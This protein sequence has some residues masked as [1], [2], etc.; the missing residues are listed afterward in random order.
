[1][2]RLVSVICIAALILAGCIDDGHVGPTRV[3][4]KIVVNA[5]TVQWQ[6]EDQE[7]V[8]CEEPIW[9]MY[10][11]A[12][13]PITQAGLRMDRTYEYYCYLLDGYYYTTNRTS[14]EGGEVTGPGG[15]L[16]LTGKREWMPRSYCA[17]TATTTYRR[18]NGDAGCQ[19]GV[20]FGSIGMT[21]AEHRP[22]YAMWDADCA[23][24]ENK[25]TAFVPPSD[26][27]T[28]CNLT[29]GE[30]AAIDDTN[31]TL[32]P[33]GIS[34]TCR[35]VQQCGQNGNGFV[36]EQAGS[37]MAGNNTDEESIFR[38]GFPLMYS[39]TIMTAD[40]IP[41]FVG[42]TFSA[43]IKSDA[44]PD[45]IPIGLT[46]TKAN[47]QNT[48]F[49]VRSDWFNDVSTEFYN[50]DQAVV[51]LY[52]RFSEGDPNSTIFDVDDPNFITNQLYDPNRIRDCY[53]VPI[54]PE[55]DSLRIEFVMDPVVFFTAMPDWLGS[56]KTFDLNQ[57]G[58]VNLEDYC[59][60]Q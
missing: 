40:P 36:V 11:V 4:D 14:C 50:P 21:N 31:P 12:G 56:N 22:K 27:S 37:F 24:A 53:I 45:G 55:N 54:E 5:G 30:Y 52:D 6:F 34:W 7:P 3:A 57:D 35:L 2:K 29:A 51:Q 59:F 43:K 44:A 48:V 39:Y 42:K 9:L 18:P 13:T 32:P 1:M 47:D 26:S 49:I 17:H 60:W 46:V 16:E 28:L 20:C 23:S 10:E 41:D 8:F 33:A 15:Q 58:I 38:H 25:Y 19:T